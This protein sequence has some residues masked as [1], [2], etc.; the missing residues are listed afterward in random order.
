MFHV[1]LF[2]VTKLHC[3]AL[4]AILIISV[5]TRGLA[6]QQAIKFQSL[7]PLPDWQTTGSMDYA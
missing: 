4:G 6:E 7:N 5:E 3:S 2:L 1:K